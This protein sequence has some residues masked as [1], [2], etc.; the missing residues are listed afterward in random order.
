MSLWAKII[1]AGVRAARPSSVDYVAGTAFAGDARD[2]YRRW[3]TG[4]SMLD[5][6]HIAEFERVLSDYFEGAN[7]TTFGSGRAALYAILKAMQIK[8]GGEVILPGY[9]CIVTPNAIRRAELTPVYVDISRRDFNMSPDAVERAITPRTCA[10]LVQHTFGIPCDVDA[11]LDIGARKGI[12]LVGDGAH[13]IGARWKDRP[14]GVWGVASFFSTQATKMLTTE[15][16]GFTVTADRE[17]AAR[18]R[19]VQ[20][21]AAFDS[22]RHERAALLRWC[23]RAAL[24]ARP[25]VTPRARAAEAFVAA[26]GAPGLAGILDFDREEYAA[27]LNGECA[28]PFPSR[29]PN[30]L[31][32]A[33]V[34]QM[35]RIEPDLAHRRELAAYL[36]SELPQRGAVIANY[37]R[38]RAAPSWVR[39]PFLVEDRAAWAAS[40]ERAGLAPGYW[41]NDPIHPKGSN[42][43]A[44]GYV[45][46]SC[47]NAEYVAEHILNIPVHSRVSL[48]RLQRWL[49]YV[50]IKGKPFA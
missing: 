26:V 13:A 21:A 29:M 9:T 10:I 40:M 28:E 37:P 48:E 36:E 16:G 47:P 39:F 46:G 3:R 19:E 12:P 41:L 18:I 44:S 17:L 32:Y 34:L 35:Q 24:F 4:E 42:W 45:R 6:P 31:A 14:I 27:A 50:G 22:E 30:L 7:A 2:V 43:Q 49:H 23:Y 25:G 5:G 20:A 11:L 33:G 15:R 38:D 8:S 1:A